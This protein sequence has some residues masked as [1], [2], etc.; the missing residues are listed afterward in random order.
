MAV[1]TGLIVKFTMSQ[2]ATTR[3][4]ADIYLYLEYTS[5]HRPLVSHKLYNFC[6]VT[7][8]INNRLLSSTTIVKRFQ[9]D[10]CE[11]F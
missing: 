11:F 4:R 3:P 6:R 7:M 5:N 10:N 1:G 9:V 8:T 2:R